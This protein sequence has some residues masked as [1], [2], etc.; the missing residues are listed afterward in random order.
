MALKAL[1]GWRRNSETSPGYLKNTA[2]HHHVRRCIDELQDPIFVHVDGSLT[3]L[4]NAVSDLLN[5]LLR[6]IKL[7]EVD[8]DLLVEEFKS[9]EFIFASNTVG[10]LN[11]AVCNWMD[12]LI[13]SCLL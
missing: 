1:V 7:S 13:Q 12:Y 11:K 6:H 3:H 4:Y 10:L 5:Y 2:Q 9:E 8:Q